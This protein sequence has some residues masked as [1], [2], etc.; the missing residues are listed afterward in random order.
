MIFFIFFFKKKFLTTYASSVT[1]VGWITYFLILCIW[2]LK[3]EK[4]QQ[5]ICES[6]IYP[7]FLYSTLIN[8]NIFYFIL[9]P[10]S[11]LSKTIQ[12]V[13]TAKKYTLK[14]AENDI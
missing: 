8:L 6:H 10:N 12:N 7:I 9:F 5:N 11:T 1:R 13:E 14:K 4:Y 3:K 2:L